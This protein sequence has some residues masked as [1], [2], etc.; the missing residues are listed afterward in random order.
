[1][2]AQELVTDRPD[3]TESVLSVP[4]GQFQLEGGV[5]YSEAGPDQMWSFG[6]MLLRI[7]ISERVE[8]RIEPGSFLEVD[9]PAGESSGW[10][11]AAVAAKIELTSAGRGGRP[12]LALIAALSLPT[13]ED[14]VGGDDPHPEAVLAASWNLSPR[15]GLGANL[16]VGESEDDAG[17]FLEGK[18][19][20]ALG[21]DLGGAWGAFVEAFAIYPESA[22]R[23]EAHFVDAGLT[24]LATE[25]FQ[26][27][28]R[29]GQ[30]LDADE[31]TFVGAGFTVR[32]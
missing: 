11:D 32:W 15:L 3:F 22:G 25:D 5:T 13:G 23:D 28:L 4:R 9:G 29:A 14:G 21:I 19:S 30:G 17:D 1:M 18:A 10:D 8:L 2:A 24:W 7:G 12:A 16:G 31:E 27:D 26:L 6:E 20:L